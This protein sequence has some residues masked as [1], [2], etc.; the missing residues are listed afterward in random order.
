MTGVEKCWPKV[1]GDW[2]RHRISRQRFLHV[3]GMGAAALL[4]GAGQPKKAAS[5]TTPTFPD[6][7]F[8]LG[9]ASGDPWPDG[10]VL[11][12]RLAPA[13]PLLGD[14]MPRRDVEVRW[15][16]AAD[17]DFSA[18]VRSGT[19]IATPELARSAHVEVGGSSRAVTTGGCR[20]PSRRILSFSVPPETYSIA[21]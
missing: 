19:S 9:V 15:E 12:T 21:M 20:A 6:Y 7:P 14:G 8:K 13:D 11:W 17:E 5:L 2:D 4:L 16:V 3:G 18:L 1:T 10:T